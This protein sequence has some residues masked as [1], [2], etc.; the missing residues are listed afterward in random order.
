MDSA[1]GR[2]T[3]VVEGALSRWPA[4]RKYL[5]I[6]RPRVLQRSEPRRMQKTAYIPTMSIRT[7]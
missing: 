2:D 6:V 5:P 4:M 1:I 3:I 7:P